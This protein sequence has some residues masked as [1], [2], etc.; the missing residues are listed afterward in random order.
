MLGGRDAFCLAPPPPLP[1]C[2]LKRPA[3]CWAVGGVNPSQELFWLVVV[4]RRLGC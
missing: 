3:F 2:S 4:A 1:P